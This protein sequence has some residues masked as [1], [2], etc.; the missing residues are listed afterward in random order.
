[1]GTLNFAGGAAL[2]GNGT[3]LTSTSGLDFGGNWTDAPIGTIIKTGHWSTGYGTASG[4]IT[5]VTSLADIGLTGTNANGEWYLYGVNHN[6]VEKS[7]FASKVANDKL[8]N[9]SKGAKVKISHVDMGEKSMYNVEP[10]NGAVST[11]TSDKPDW[12]AIAAGKVRHGFAVEAFKMGKELDKQTMDE[13]GV[14]VDYVI[15]GD[16]DLPF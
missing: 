8:V 13:I 5:A 11:P 12:D 15:N 6:G 2:S 9:Y 4:L 10:V 14:W 7:F 3:N 16:A 1:M